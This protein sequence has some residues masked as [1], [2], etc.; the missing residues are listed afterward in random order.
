[1]AE[2]MKSAKGRPVDNVLV[3]FMIQIRPQ[4]GHGDADD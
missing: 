4:H 3:A 1:V 2:H